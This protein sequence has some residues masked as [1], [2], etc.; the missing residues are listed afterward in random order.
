MMEVGGGGP[1]LCNFQILVLKQGCIPKTRCLGSVLKVC[2]GFGCVVVKPNLV[3]HF[4]PSLH[5]WTLF[6][7]CARAKPFNF[8]TKSKISP[9]F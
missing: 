9:F 4:A 6:C 5:L 2:G 1:F 8:G 3:K 7:V